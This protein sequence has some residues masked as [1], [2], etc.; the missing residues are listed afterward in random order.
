MKGKQTC[1]ILKEIRKQIAEENDIE[2]V[3]SECTYQGDCKG[4]CPKCEAEVRYLERELEKRQRMGKAAVFAGM[5]LGTL[6]AATSCDNLPIPQPL[7][8]EPCVP[9][10]TE[11]TNDS[12]PSDTVPEEPFLLEGDVVA[13]MPDTMKAEEKKTA[14]KN[15]EK[16]E[17]VGGVEDDDM[18]T[19]GFVVPNQ[20]INDSDESEVYMI[21]DQMPEF[22]SGDKGLYQFIADNIKYPAEAKEEGIK[23]RVFVNF[24][25][26][27]DGSVS[28]IRVLR[29]IGGGCDEEAVRVVKSMPRFK[30]GMQGGDAVRVSYTVPVNFKLSK[31]KSWQKANKPASDTMDVTPEVGCVVPFGQES[32]PENDVYM[33]VE[34]MPEFPGG[35]SK[36]IE[37]VSKNICCPQEVKEAPIS[38]KVFVKFIVEPDGS[39]SNAEVLKGVGFGWDEEAVR[40]VM[41]MPKWK[42]GMQNGKPIRVSY[43]LPIHIDLNN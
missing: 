9:D 27:P 37:F 20:W 34:Q 1:K 36:L 41:S 29:G 43:M 22:P 8:G 11:M 31:E 16:L 15:N 30:P 33:F 18:V 5:S 7:A 14:C 23:G 24:I 21:V 32:D 38:G 10:T 17:I 39:I 12:I 26:E 2:L 4:T 3:T 42:P 25:V 13:P 19:E 28:D 6:F 35:E 40:V